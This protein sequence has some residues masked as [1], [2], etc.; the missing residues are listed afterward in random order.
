MDDLIVLFSNVRLPR[1]GIIFGLGNPLLDLL[2]D[3]D[4]EFLAKYDLKANDA[5][6]A[7]DKHK[8]LD[9]VLQE[10]YDVKYIAGGSVQNTMRIAEWML[11]FKVLYQM[12]SFITRMYHSLVFLLLIPA[13][14]LHLHGVYR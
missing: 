1:E 10:K 13:Q 7:G 5:I 3:V 14:Y 11:G 4:G 8:D 12:K 2:A 9:K 6:L